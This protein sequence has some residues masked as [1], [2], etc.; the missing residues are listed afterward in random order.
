MKID[1]VAVVVKNLDEALKTYR[2]AFGLPVERVEDVPAEGVSIAFLPFSDG[3]S[4]LELLEP[5][6]PATGA[7]KFLAKRGEG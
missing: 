4:E 1:H 7:G 6:Q 3:N 5:T 2:D